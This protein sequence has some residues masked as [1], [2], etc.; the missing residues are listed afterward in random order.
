MIPTPPSQD[1]PCHQF[2]VER[3][4][5]IEFKMQTY[6]SSKI[7]ETL[8]N[9]EAIEWYAELCEIDE[10]FSKGGTVIVRRITV[11]VNNKFLYILPIA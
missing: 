4:V 3:A 7:N 1:G 11:A 9:T 6:S 5:C 8:R 2:N 10:T